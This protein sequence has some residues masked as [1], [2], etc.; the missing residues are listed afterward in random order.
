MRAV[1]RSAGAGRRM[2]R[3]D[4]KAGGTPAGR[5]VEEQRDRPHSRR[6]RRRRVD[7]ERRV[8][9]DATTCMRS[10]LAT[11]VAAAREVAGSSGRRKADVVAGEDPWRVEDRS[12]AP[13]AGRP[14]CSAHVYSTADLCGHRRPGARV[15]TL[16]PD[17]TPRMTAPDT[18]SCI[19]P[20]QARVVSRWGGAWLGVIVVSG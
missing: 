11:S 18:I 14:W 9:F 4:R 6:R 19:G 3:C 10:S 12:A 17:P 2:R 20:C 15:P 5:R 13:P 16:A 7:G 8:E 1:T